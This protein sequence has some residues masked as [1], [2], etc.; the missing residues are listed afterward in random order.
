VVIEPR[1]WFAQWKGVR[2]TIEVINR[3]YVLIGA[4]S[5]LGIDAFASDDGVRDFTVSV[6]QLH[7]VS[8]FAAQQY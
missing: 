4:C 6:F 8:Q 3:T 5:A 1:N 2:V 7:S